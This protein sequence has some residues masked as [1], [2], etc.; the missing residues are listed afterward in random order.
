M[1]TRPARLKK[2]L[3]VSYD[4]DEQ[5]W[6]YDFVAATSAGAAQ[7]IVENSRPYVIAA[8]ATSEPELGRM[9]FRFDKLTPAETA[10]KFK[11]MIANA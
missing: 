8:D 5:Q 9:H 2:F 1:R 3:V 6:F 4:D 11:L 10:R 7:Q